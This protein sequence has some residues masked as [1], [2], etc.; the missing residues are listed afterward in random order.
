METFIRQLFADPDM[1]RM[2]HHQRAED[3][4]LGL[5]W[6]YY[7]LGR[8]ARPAKAVV[9]GS[10][11]GFVPAVL[12]KALAENVEGGQVLFIDPSWADG[13]WREPNHVTGH[14]ERLGAPNVTHWRLSTQEFVRTEDYRALSGIGLLMVDGY[15][16]AEQAR[17]DYLAFL[18]KLAEDSVVMFHDS[19]QRRMSSFYG[20]E[21]RYEHTVCELMDRLRRTPGLE[22]FSLPFGGGLTLVRG[23]PQTMTVIN[24]PFQ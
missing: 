15:H 23:R 10:F 13:F 2:G 14:F 21:R 19:V 8:L 7:A 20:E 22:V 17:F 6:I 18:D 16:T 3:L 11:R 12:A 1:L 24:E 5:G 9:I 4:N